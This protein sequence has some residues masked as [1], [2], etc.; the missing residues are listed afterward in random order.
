[1]CCLE[2][3]IG[4]RHYWE[5]EILVW[6]K[7]KFEMHVGISLILIMLRHHVRMRRLIVT[8]SSVLNSVSLDRI[9]IKFVTWILMTPEQHN[10]VNYFLAVRQMSGHIHYSVVTL[11]VNKMCPG[12]YFVKHIDLRRQKIQH[13]ANFKPRRIFCLCVCH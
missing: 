7:K 3:V 2:S 6:Y 13:V 1:M 10:S 12:I 11:T 9:K 4:K 8:S 5:Y